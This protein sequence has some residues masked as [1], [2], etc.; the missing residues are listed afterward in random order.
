MDDLHAVSWPSRASRAAISICLSDLRT[1]RSS[2][3]ECSYRTGAVGDQLFGTGTNTR[4]VDG[5]EVPSM[6]HDSR[7]AGRRI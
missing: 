5:G 7:H 2:Y 4:K 6:C 3:E 1:G